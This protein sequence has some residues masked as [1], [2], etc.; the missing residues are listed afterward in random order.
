MNFHRLKESLMVKVCGAKLT[1]SAI[2]CPFIEG[3]CL[4]E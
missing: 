2:N 4:L 1:Y 3:L